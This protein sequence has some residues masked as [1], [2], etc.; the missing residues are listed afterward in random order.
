[1][2]QQPLDGSSSQTLR[3]KPWALGTDRKTG[4]VDK[5][6][7]E[8]R[9]R[10]IH[11]LIKLYQGKAEGEL[12]RDSDPS[13]EIVEHVVVRRAAPIDRMHRACTIDGEMHQAG[14]RFHADF[15]RAQLLGRYGTI[16][17][18]GVS[19][20]GKSE[21]GD[22]VVAARERVKHALEALGHRP[23]ASRVSASAEVC[24]WILGEEATIKEFVQRVRWGGRDMNEGK[25]SGIL[26]GVLEALAL[27][28]GLI[29]S[30]RMKSREYQRGV[31][32][33]LQHAADRATVEA[34][35]IASREGRPE[36][37]ED[38]LNR[39]AGELRSLRPLA[40]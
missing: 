1:L 37:A 4:K 6:H 15:E 13:G 8:V 14:Q 11:Q 27:H 17:L 12:I 23:E 31:R 22:Q 16:H 34:A 26:I 24:W 36:S 29:D 33:G 2:E 38:V 35:A 18:D 5:R 32:A 9:R 28:Y 25:A 7:D 40:A 10:E 20:R 39:F 19:A 21:M 3:L 30:R